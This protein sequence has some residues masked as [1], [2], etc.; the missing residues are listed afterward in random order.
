MLTI[1]KL[2]IYEQFDGDIDGWVR[3][4]SGQATAGMTDA[5]WYLIDELL[6]GLAVVNAGVAS[7]AYSQ[8]VEQL[9]LANTDEQATRSCLHAL[10]MRRG[11]RNAASVSG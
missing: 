10:A 9:L 7:P 5:D 1:E 4:S 6:L 8:Q 2:R 11:P 3:T